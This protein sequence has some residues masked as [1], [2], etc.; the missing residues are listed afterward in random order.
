[1]LESDASSVKNRDD[2]DF[3]LEGLDGA[4]ESARE[5]RSEISLALL[6]I[7][8]VKQQQ[9]QEADIV[10]LQ[11]RLTTQDE[12]NRATPFLRTVA[13]NLSELPAVEYYLAIRAEDGFYRVIVPHV[14]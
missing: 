9:S 11:Q 1:M 3:F 7:D 8:T 6:S 10:Q 5:L 14:Y 2:S 4:S 13:D 12:M